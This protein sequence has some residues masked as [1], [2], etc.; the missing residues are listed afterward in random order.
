MTATD[1][2]EYLAW[3]LNLV[4]FIQQNQNQNPTKLIPSL[5]P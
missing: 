2:L 5:K 1:H 3:F 4:L